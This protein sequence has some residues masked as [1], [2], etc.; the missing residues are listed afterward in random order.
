MT[1]EQ[2]LEYI[3]KTPSNT[4]VNVLSGMLD[5]LIAD[6]APEEE[7]KEEYVPK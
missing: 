6:S 2:I 4:N 3:M 1:K 7:E 5:S